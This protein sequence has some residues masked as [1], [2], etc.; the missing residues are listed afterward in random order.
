MKRKGLE[1]EI[2]DPGELIRYSLRRLIGDYGR[3]VSETRRDEMLKDVHLLEAAL[4]A[5]RTVISIEV[6]AR[7]WYAQ[8]SSTIRILA[9]V[10]WID[11]SRPDEDATDWLRQGARPE[12]QRKL[13]AWSKT[14]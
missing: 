14:L 9:A 11:P 10:V 7:N 13:R 4:S 12:P 5:D 3:T 2:S 6:N 1:F 8:A